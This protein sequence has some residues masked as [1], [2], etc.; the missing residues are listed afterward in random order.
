M[1]SRRRYLLSFLETN[2]DV[3]IGWNGWAGGSAWPL[4]Y[5]LNLNPNADGS[6]RVQMTQAFLKHLTPPAQ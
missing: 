5:A 2:S 6:D 1:L 4:D 3:F